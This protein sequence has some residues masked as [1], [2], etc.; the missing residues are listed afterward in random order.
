MLKRPFRDGTLD[1]H[2]GPPLRN[3]TYNRGVRGHEIEVGYIIKPLLKKWWGT[4]L[5]NYQK[6]VGQ[7]PKAPPMVTPLHAQSFSVFSCSEVSKYV[8]F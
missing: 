8:S 7:C 3:V 1:A 5:E 6:V 2:S 4:I